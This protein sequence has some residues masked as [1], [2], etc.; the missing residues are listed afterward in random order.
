MTFEKAAGNSVSCGFFMR[1]T[2]FASSLPNTGSS[3]ERDFPLIAFG[4]ILGTHHTKR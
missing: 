2:L 1:F 3:P 4:A